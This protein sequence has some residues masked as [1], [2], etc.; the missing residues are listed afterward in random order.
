MEQF[1][2]NYW[3][4]LGRPLEV[5]AE[6]YGRARDHHKTKQASAK[7][8][9][10]LSLAVAFF[11]VAAAATSFRV[12]EHSLKRAMKIRYAS[13]PSLVE[14]RVT[15][16]HAAPQIPATRRAAVNGVSSFIVP[17]SGLLRDAILQYVALGARTVFG[18]ET[19]NA[20]T[21]EY[22][23]N[24][25]TTPPDLEL[26]SGERQLIRLKYTNEGTHNWRRE[27]RSFISLYVRAK[28]KNLDAS[29]AGAAKNASNVFY[30]ASW[31]STKQVARITD[32]LVGPGRAGFVEFY[33]RAPQK[34]GA[35]TA[36]FQLAAENT[37]WVQGS[38]V[39]VTV[40]VVKEKT[41]ETENTAQI[42]SGAEIVNEFSATSAPE[43]RAGF[44]L[45]LWNDGIPEAVAAAAATSSA[46]STQ[47]ETVLPAEMIAT[48]TSREEPSA[49]S[50][51]NIRVGLYR[52]SEPVEF[53]SDN[54]YEL[55]DTE[56]VLYGQIP[57]GQA[58]ILKYDVTRKIYRA[59]SDTGY[60]ESALPLR[61]LPR[62][63]STQSIF[64]L[65]DAKNFRGRDKKINYNQFRG[66]LELRFANKHTWVI[67]ELPT[68]H[69]LNGLAE[70]GEGAPE[71]FLKALAI[72]ARSFA[73][74]AIQN[75]IKH[76]RSQFNV[77][78]EYDQIY[79]G[80]VR[81]NANPSWVQAVEETRGIVVTYKNEPVTA[82]YF[83][84]SAG[85]TRAWSEVWRGARAWLVS[86]K[87]PYDKGR[88]RLGHG[89]GMSTH[90][91]L[92]RAKKGATAEEIL[93][94]YYRGT[95]VQKLW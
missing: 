92:I 30:D 72:A 48:S 87:A 49:T 82:P 83:A 41:R 23:A 20:A 54:D 6:M 71:E 61:L 75:P 60:A 56:S 52:A 55:R 51:P 58:T 37:A 36:R 84:Q 62:A 45:N 28:G 22:V 17:K 90:D 34:I 81:A 40:R 10:F 4:E 76:P 11:I 80:V 74:E 67:N 26:V 9:I 32:P 93:K 42:G 53:I 5:Y 57:A 78:A 95:E 16:Q 21:T 33:I 19:A 38:E 46:A 8:G 85:R 24:L 68:E 79:K 44:P 47:A 89:V 13:A 86:V 18:V 29:A 64:T 50:T 1:F 35:Y 77:D 91:A 14:M 12:A 27:G 59:E 43:A 88:K 94:Y 65:R 73:Y 3:N 63:A 31:M 2:K 7:Q 39:T 70:A 25:A 69:Y 66:A 15:D